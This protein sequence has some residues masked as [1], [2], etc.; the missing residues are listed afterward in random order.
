MDEEARLFF[1]AVKEPNSHSTHRH[2]KKGHV[3]KYVNRQQLTFH[4]S[5]YLGIKERKGGDILQQ[6]PIVCVTFFG[7]RMK[8]YILPRHSEAHCQENTEWLQ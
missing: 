6:F 4:A 5:E 7:N 3:I 8:V 2:S 1:T